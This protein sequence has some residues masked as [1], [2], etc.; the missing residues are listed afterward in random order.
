[1]NSSPDKNILCNRCSEVIYR[2]NID[3]DD[4][5]NTV[6]KCQKCNAPNNLNSCKEENDWSFPSLSSYLEHMAKIGILIPS[7]L[8]SC[9]H[10]CTSVNIIPYDF[11]QVS[12]KKCSDLRKFVSNLYCDKC[13]SFL[14]LGNIYD[15]SDSIH[16]IWIRENIWMEWYI[17]NIIKMN[18]NT[19]L[20]E[21]GLTI[22]NHGSTQTD[23]LLLKND[24]IISYECKNIG[25]T[26]N[27][28]FEEVSDVLNYLD[29]SD[30]VFLVI[31]T[32]LTENDKIRLLNRGN[33]KLKIIECLDVDQLVK[34]LD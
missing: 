18:L 17:K 8:G 7:I 21:Q 14:E 2:Y 4:K 26:K 15:V 33:N 23:V 22:S 3:F 31:P 6:I 27:I 20:V 28:N 29:F 25:L 1:M 32:K 30:E 9:P 10:Y 24:K 19:D 13:G 11:K 34:Y 12:T 16:S 5:L